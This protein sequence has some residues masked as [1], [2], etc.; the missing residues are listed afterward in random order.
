[1][2]ERNDP[3]QLTQLLKSLECKAQ[4]PSHLLDLF[5][6][7]GVIEPRFSER[8]RFVRRHFPSKAVLELSQ[9][10]PG[11][12]RDH[13]FCCIFTKDMSRNSIA[14]LHSEQLY[15][16]EKLLLWL[17]IG[18]LRC[19]VSRCCRHNSQCFEICAMIC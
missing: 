19:R 3:G 15:P 6:R 13:E 18:K 7:R 1:M 9:T 8:R 10:V 14:F 16:G 12:S 17:P 4:L 11:I 2:L 5:S